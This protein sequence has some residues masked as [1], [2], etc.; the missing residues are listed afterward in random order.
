[1]WVNEDALSGVGGVPSELSSELQPVTDLFR[2][3]SHPRLPRDGRP[4]VTGS[5]GDHL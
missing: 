3:P 4:C 5:T 1:M 2:T